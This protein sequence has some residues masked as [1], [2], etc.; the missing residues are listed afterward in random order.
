MKKIIPSTLTAA[1]NLR[2][3]AEEMLNTRLAKGVVQSTEADLLKL[4]HELEVHKIELEIQKSELQIANQKA[5][6]FAENKYAEIYDLAPTGYFTLS[7]E[8]EILGLNLGGARML[9]KERL[10]MINSP[11]GFF[12]SEETKPVFN[13]FLEEIFTS[14]SSEICEITLTGSGN[15]H[16]FVQLTG[17]ESHVGGQCLITMADITVTKM[18]EERLRESE[19]S[20]HSLIS[21]LHVGVLVQGPL[22]EILV[23]NN[24]ALELLGLTEDQLLGKTSFDSDWNVIHE[25]GTPYPGLT[26]PVPQSIATRKPVRNAVMGVYRPLTRDRVWLL[27]NADPE[28]NPD[29]SIKE[30]ICTFKDITDRKNAEEELNRSRVF[31]NSII[32]HSPNSLWISDEKGTLIRMNQTCRDKL[33]LKDDEVINKYNILKDNIIEEQGLMPLVKTVFENGKT[34]SFVISYDTANI[35]G[36]SLGRTVKVELDVA[37]SPILGSDGKV[38]N[39]IIQ[40]T[41]ITAKRDAENALRESEDRFRTVVESSLIPIVVHRNG[42]FV[43][44]NPAAIKVFGA[45]AATD[46]LETPVL[47]RIHP[48]YHKI[49][50][51]RI[52]KADDMATKGLLIEAKYLRLDGKIFDAE[53][54]EAPIVYDGKPAIH[55]SIHDITE[56]NLVAEKLKQ[57]STRLL[58]ATRAGHI[59]VWEYNI[60]TN[61]ILWDDQM[62][63]LYRTDKTKFGGNLESWLSRV[64]PE[65][66]LRVFNEN[67]MAIRGEKELDTE[68][69]VVWP[70]GTVRNI[71]AIGIVQRDQSGNP[72]CIIGTNW[73]ITN[74]KLAEAKIIEK[75]EELQRVIAEKDKFFSIIAH[76]LRS[77]F[78]GFLGLTQLLSEE[79]SGMTPEEIR[80]AA[81]LM[82]NS[83]TNLFNL[84]GNLL[85]WSRLQRGL[86][87]FIPAAVLLIEKYNVCLLLLEDLRA[88]KQITFRNEIPPELKVIADGDMLGS[89]LHNLLTNGMKFTPRGGSITVSAR[90]VSNKEVEIS[91]K[92]SGI[93]MNKQMIDNL[94]RLDVNTGRNGTEGELSTGLGL[95]ICND[96]I[97]KHGGKLVVESEEGKGSIFS[98][99]L[100][101]AN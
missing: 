51:D 2:I 26:H 69:R 56:R 37:I 18:R 91:I 72:L 11:F 98:F 23:S 96:F 58:L 25:D 15:M 5:A 66:K 16:R 75:R 19:K 68:Y 78:N 63:L 83:A 70:D 41:D 49:I 62:F 39:A 86:T 52:R 42:K 92:D 12:I 31:L 20:Y 48:D 85:E 94:F 64:H 61:I 99:I 46:L 54:L 28:L 10:N 34:V 47:D 76:D 45:T 93:G 79:I 95:N 77:P 84:L 71:R 38:T 55:A 90:S 53:V 60:D 87:P 22:S 59:G 82:R 50:R 3:K 57:L 33:Q 101:A 24:R 100:P 80:Q 21:N 40:H 74:Q 30:V 81:E 89:I 73:D 6:E 4:V 1:D 88:K 43:F 32:E 7:K 17:I 65:D 9:G 13:H 29:G 44:V 36:L 67:Q 8:G 14:K 35:T 27:V 97:E